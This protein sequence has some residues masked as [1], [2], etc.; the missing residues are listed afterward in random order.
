MIMKEAT[1]SLAVL[2]LPYGVAYVLSDWMAW[3]PV[4]VYVVL[5]RHSLSKK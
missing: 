5:S 2:T 4:T 1:S 3:R